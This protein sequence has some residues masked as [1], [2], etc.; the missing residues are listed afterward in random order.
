MPLTQNDEEAVELY[1]C[2]EGNQAI[3]NILRAAR[4][5][6]GHRPAP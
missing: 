6:E 4:I 1:E 2:H 3:S 5:A